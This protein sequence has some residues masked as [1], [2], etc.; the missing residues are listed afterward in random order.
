MALRLALSHCVQRSPKD[1]RFV[2]GP[3]G[4]PRLVEATG[5]DTWH[6]SLARSGDCCL[7]AA[8]RIGPVGVDVEQVTPL[9]DLD[10]IAVHHFA[11]QEVNEILAL[12]GASRLRAFFQCWTRKE[13]YLKATGLGL[14]AGLDGFTVG[15]GDRPVILRAPDNDQ[16]RWTVTTLNPGANLIGALALRG[17]HQSS[18]YPVRELAL[19]CQR[20]KD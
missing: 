19:G 12:A 9:P 4:K 20:M 10:E 7:I 18:N 5:D 11:T 16:D 8:T 17:V 1:L 6:F 3:D 2:L 15:V 14:T 13:A